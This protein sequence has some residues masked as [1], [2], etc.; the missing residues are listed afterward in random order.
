[1]WSRPLTRKVM[2]D[3]S[4]EKVA[5]DSG[6][7]EISYRDPSAGTVGEKTLETGSG[8]T[9]VRNSTPL[10]SSSASISTSGGNPVQGPG[11][12]RRASTI[13]SRSIEPVHQ[14]PVEGGSTS[15]RKPVESTGTIADPASKSNE[16]NVVASESSDVISSSDVRTTVSPTSCRTTPAITDPLRNPPPGSLPTDSTSTATQNTAITTSTS[17]EPA[18]PPT[19]SGNSDYHPTS[20]SSGSNANSN[21]SSSRR[22][23][24]GLFGINLDLNF[25]PS[26]WLVPS[27]VAGRSISS[28]SVLPDWV[29]HPVSII[30]NRSSDNPASQSSSGL[31]EGRQQHHN[32]HGSSATGASSRLVTHS[33]GAGTGTAGSNWNSSSFQTSSSIPSNMH[34]HHHQHPHHGHGP[35]PLRTRHTVVSSM[36]SVDEDLDAGMNSIAI[37][38]SLLCNMHMNLS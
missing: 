3:S 34:H 7:E 37:V 38:K 36:R 20:R 32:H 4:R 13:S 24:N 28:L 33:Q 35:I 19:M 16:N 6:T 5:T 1:M 26:S 15:G 8:S 10:L 25:D 22:Q 30:P 14:G 23:R 29:R 11:S 31:T 17:S 12:S 21:S 9:T 2:T 18:A 27:N